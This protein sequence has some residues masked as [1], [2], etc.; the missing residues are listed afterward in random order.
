MALCDDFRKG[1]LPLHCLNFGTIIL[2]PKSSDANQ[3]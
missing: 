3:I 2:L 1:A